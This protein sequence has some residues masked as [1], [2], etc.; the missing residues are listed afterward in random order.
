MDF[1]TNY[2][3]FTYDTNSNSNSRVS[4]SESDSSNSPLK[5]RQEVNARERFRTQSRVSSV[6]T[7][8]NTLRTLIP[9]EPSDRKLSKIEILRLAKSY[10]AHLDAIVLTGTTE[11][12]CTSHSLQG[13]NCAVIEG[14][15]GTRSNICTFCAKA[16][17]ARS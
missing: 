14:D 5:P 11:K 16:I 3:N 6:N 10:I 4:P 17:N 9:T 12:P 8:F 2:Q 13:H 15:S 7:A 1:Y